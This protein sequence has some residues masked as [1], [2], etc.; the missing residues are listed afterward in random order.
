MHIHSLRHWFLQNQQLTGVLNAGDISG[1]WVSPLSWERTLHPQSL[2]LISHSTASEDI[3][4]RALVPLTQ[5]KVCGEQVWKHGLKQNKAVSFTPVL[6][7]TFNMLTCIMQLQTYPD[8]SVTNVSPTFWTRIL[9]S[10]FN[11]MS[12]VSSISHNSPHTDWPPL[13]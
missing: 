4:C 11:G 12:Y 13:P 5:K 8:Y 10:F 1:L 6:L 9:V 3:I 7:R 2:H